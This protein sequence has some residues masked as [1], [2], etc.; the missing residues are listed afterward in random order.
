[1]R[2]RPRT[3]VES[4][5]AAFRREAGL[6]EISSSS[7]AC[8]GDWMKLNCGDVVR[9]RA[10]RHEG[11]VEAI[12]WGTTVTVRWENGWISELL[13]VDVERVRP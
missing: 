10:G 11:R 4:P 1:M 9:E 3:V 12:Q 2:T 13:L 6:P 8:V 7:R 5:N